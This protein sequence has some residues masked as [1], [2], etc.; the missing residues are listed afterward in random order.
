[1]QRTPVIHQ[2]SSHELPGLSRHAEHV[3][4]SHAVVF[5]YDSQEEND[6]SSKN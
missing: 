4:G 6:R 2:L 5:E 1:M 3:T